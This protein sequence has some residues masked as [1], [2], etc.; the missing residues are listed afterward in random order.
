MDSTAYLWPVGSTLILNCTS[1]PIT[2]ICVAESLV[3]VTKFFIP[4]EFSLCV[5]AELLQSCLTLCDAMDCSPPGSLSMGF[6]RQEYCNG[7]PCSPPGDLPNPGMEPTSLNIT[8]T[9]S[10]FLPL[11]PPG[12]P[13]VFTI[14]I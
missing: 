13:R 11:A 3:L 2:D 6:S 4:L 7:L 1:A 9:G 5:C 8:C 10:G 14:D 12:K